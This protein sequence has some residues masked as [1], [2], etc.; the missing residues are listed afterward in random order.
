MDQLYENEWFQRAGGIIIES[1]LEYSFD[2]LCAVYHFLGIIH[3]GWLTDDS[4]IT[5]IYLYILF[6]PLLTWI[7][8]LWKFSCDDNVIAKWQ[9]YPMT[10]LQD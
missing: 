6:Q 2:E 3:H 1:I 9:Q 4:I 10:A 7:L 8:C 5:S